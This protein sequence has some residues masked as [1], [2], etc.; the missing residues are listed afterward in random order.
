MVLESEPANA[1]KYVG[2]VQNSYVKFGKHLLLTYLE[3][4]PAIIALLDIAGFLT[5]CLGYC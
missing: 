3:F 4:N 5:A 1:I 2:T